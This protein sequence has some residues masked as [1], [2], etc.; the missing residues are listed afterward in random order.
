MEKLK[1]PPRS[2]LSYTSSRANMSPSDS[3]SILVRD[4]FSW[5]F[6]KAGR[7]NGTR[8][9]IGGEYLSLPSTLMTN[10]GTSL[11]YGKR[12]EILS[13]NGLNSPAP[14]AYQSDLRFL[15]TFVPGPK[16]RKSTSGGSRSPTISPS[17]GPGHYQTES[18]IGADAPMFTLK[19][20][21]KD[22][23][24]PKSPGPESYRPS[25]TLTSP[26]RFN[27]I[28]FGSSQR[29]NLG[30]RTDTYPGPGTYEMPSRFSLPKLPRLKDKALHTQN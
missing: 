27:S 4:N 1:T 11:G 8:S 12:S 3:T 16:Y 2:K 17:P 22:L 18:P 21:P 24:S 29:S 28:K 19:Y 13:A 25:E 9:S 7:F 20:R 6:S 14:S 5:T 30:F 26:K 15:K 10:S 23:T